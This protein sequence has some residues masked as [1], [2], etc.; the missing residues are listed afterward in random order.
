MKNLK[1]A[2]IQT[3]TPLNSFYCYTAS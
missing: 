2:K 3:P 1:S